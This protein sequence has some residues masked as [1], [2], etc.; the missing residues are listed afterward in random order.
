MWSKQ[1]SPVLKSW[2]LTQQSNTLLS[3]LFPRDKGHNSH[4]HYRS[5]SGK[6]KHTV[7]CIRHLNNHFLWGQS[8]ASVWSHLF[9]FKSRRQHLNIHKPTCV[10]TSLTICEVWNRS[11]AFSHI[12]EEMWNVFLNLFCWWISVSFFP[13]F[14]YQVILFVSNGSFLII[15]TR[16]L[17]E[18][19]L[20][21]KSWDGSFIDCWFSC[22][23]C[24]VIFLKMHH[25]VVF[26]SGSSWIRNCWKLCRIW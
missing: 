1:Q 19:G 14:F 26:I 10:P 21:T 11:C 20:N 13:D 4:S 9:T 15:V 8:H 3:H 25:L 17:L 23:F 22:F 24:H 12:L 6:R 2:T 5:W 16:G 7:V 18:C